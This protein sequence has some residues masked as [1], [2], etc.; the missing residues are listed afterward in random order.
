M[1]KEIENWWKQAESDFIKAE[2]L[3]KTKNFDGTAFYCQQCVEKGLK[4]LYM[5]K[6]AENPPK[7]HDLILLSDKLGAP[8]RIKEVG[9][10]LTPTYILSR[11][12]GIT[13][14]IPAELYSAQQGKDFLNLAKEAME[15]IK[16]E[17]KQ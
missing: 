15:W 5:V 2:N 11:Y 4:A 13:E 16:K 3:F 1:R 9:R 12:P 17:L 8:E 14:T 10:R 6:F 7:T